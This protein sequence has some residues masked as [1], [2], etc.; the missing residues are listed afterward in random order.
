MGEDPTPIAPE[1]ARLGVTIAHL[2]AGT[3]LLL[4]VLGL[5]R[6]DGSGGTEALTVFTV[7]PLTALVWTVLGLVGIGMS[8]RPDGARRYLVGVGAILLAW[9]ALGLVLDGEPSDLF[10]RDRELIGLHA[11][12]GVL[13]LVT[14]LTDAP[15]RLVRAP[16]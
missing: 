13:A 15:A 3:L 1:R 8:V 14:A 11:L 6:T 9:A 10:V 4:G 16:E 12:L 7:H 5:L 2:V